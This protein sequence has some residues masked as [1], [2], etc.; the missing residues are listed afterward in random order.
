MRCCAQ[1]SLVGARW[2]RRNFS[3]SLPE[4]HSPG[5]ASALR[6]GRLYQFSPTPGGINPR[7]IVLVDLHVSKTPGRANSAPFASH[8]AEQTTTRYH[9]TASRIA[10]ACRLALSA[11]VAK[12]DHTSCP[13]MI[14]LSLR[15]EP[16]GPAPIPSCLLSGCS[17]CL[18]SGASRVF[19][20]RL[21]CLLA[22]PGP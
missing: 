9:A 4:A 3:P 18:Q 21:L 12:A 20:F 11:L 8:M 5:S 19:F 10:R 14:F 7:T 17:P 2:R 15:A 1:Y 16:P 22:R 6:V 13:S